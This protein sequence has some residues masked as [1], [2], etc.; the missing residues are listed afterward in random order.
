MSDTSPSARSSAPQRECRSPITSGTPCW[1]PLGM[2][3]TGFRYRGR[4]RPGHRLRPRTQDHRPAASPGA[5]DGIAG[6]RSGPFLALNPFYVDGP[7]YGG[8]VG[9]V[10]DAGRFLRMH[11]NDGELDGNRVLAPRTARDMRRL[12]HPGKPFDH[13]I[14]W[15]RRPTNG[16]GDWVEHFG[17]GAGFW[18]V[19]R[20]Y[21]DRGVGVVVM[22]NTTQ[23]VRLRAALRVAVGRRLNGTRIGGR[24]VRRSV[25][26]RGSS[27]RSGS[28][29]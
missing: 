23:Q 2:Y 9:D 22:A 28:Q 24:H 10:L 8:L 25:V 16:T 5:P 17:A 13:G 15:F 27:S 3:H 21:P 6:D 11:L 19:M 20:L 14:G 1:Q 29:R 7:A 18:N 12:D 26:V 4:H